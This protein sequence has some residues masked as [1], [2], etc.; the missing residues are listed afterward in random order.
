MG[1]ALPVR[2]GA[3]PVRPVRRCVAY[4]GIHVPQRELD[5]IGGT[6]PEALF[7]SRVK[8]VRHIEDSLDNV[9]R[10]PHPAWV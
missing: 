6:E 7:G 5:Q 3:R 1:E 2:F 8:R 9:G 4:A 10:H